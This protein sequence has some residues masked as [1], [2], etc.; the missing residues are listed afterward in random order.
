MSTLSL[1]IHLLVVLNKKYFLSF[2]YFYICVNVIVII[3]YHLICFLY[4]FPQI[5]VRKRVEGSEGYYK[6]KI[7]F[8][9]ILFETA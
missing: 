8:T 7:K 5:L 6:R 9:I 4:S 2:F 3:T 1:S